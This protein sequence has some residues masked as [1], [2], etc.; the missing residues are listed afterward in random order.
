MATG[1]NLRVGDAERESVAAELREHYAQGRL[2]LED[3]E[4]RFDAAMA[5]KTRGDLDQLVRDLPHTKPPG[6]P[7]P[8]PASGNWRQH[9]RGHG[10]GYGG[11]RRR[12]MLGRIS[13][14]LAAVA[15]VLIVFDVMAGLRFPLPGKLGLLVAIFVFIRGLLRWMFRFGRRRF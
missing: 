12:A 5:A 13:A 8:A 4:R 11:P 2:T 15:S 7:L 6:T 1:D 10:S 14:L 9:G 3:F